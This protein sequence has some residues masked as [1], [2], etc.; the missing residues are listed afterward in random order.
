MNYLKDKQ[1]Y[2]DR[3]DMGTIEFCLDWYQSIFDSFKKNRN[4]KEFKNIFGEDFCM[5][6]KFILFEQLGYKIR[7]KVAHGEIKFNECNFQN[8]TLVLY[9]YLS[10]LGRIEI[11]EKTE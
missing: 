11:K 4:D 5:Q 7:H 1:E 8:T 2:I 6:I 10:L 9:L 3:Y